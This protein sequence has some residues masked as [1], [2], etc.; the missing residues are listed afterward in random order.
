MEIN[1]ALCMG[2][3]C[4]KALPDLAVHR[5]P[6]AMNLTKTGASHD[7]PPLAKLDAIERM[8]SDAGYCGSEY[9]GDPERGVR[10]LI[11]QH[12]AQWELLKKLEKENKALQTGVEL[13]E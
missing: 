9:H 1:G 10:E 8:L 12:R 7:Q 6:P 11:A 13:Y 4:K 5:K 3:I 2:R